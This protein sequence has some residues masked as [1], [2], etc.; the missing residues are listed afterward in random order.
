MGGH[1]DYMST[2]ITDITKN[3]K[4][5]DVAL[6]LIIESFIAGKFYKGPAITASAWRIENYSLLRAVDY[7]DKAEFLDAQVKL[8]SADTTVQAE[9][10]TQLD[11]YLSA[12]LAVKNRFPKE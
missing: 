5:D 11:A 2:L 3:I 9:G 4:L 10:Q 6:N 1:G 7:P 12:C 8:S